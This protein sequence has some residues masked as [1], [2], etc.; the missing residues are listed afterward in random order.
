MWAEKDTERES[1]FAPALHSKQP[2][3]VKHWRQLFI[4]KIERGTFPMAGSSP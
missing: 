2:G 4:R 3:I 1:R